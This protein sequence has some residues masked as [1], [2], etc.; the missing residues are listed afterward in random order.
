MRFTV[1]SVILLYPHL[2]LKPHF[3]ML[4]K[5]HPGDYWL[6]LYISQTLLKEALAQ[7][8]MLP[9]VLPLAKLK[10]MKWKAE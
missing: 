1:A 8:F 3:K 5:M 4:N 2:F 10:I 6:F 7:R 9:T